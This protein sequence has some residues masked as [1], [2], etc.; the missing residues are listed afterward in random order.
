MELV[1][2][3]AFAQFILT[4]LSE[5]VLNAGLL[6]ENTQDRTIERCLESKPVMF[7]MCYRIM[8]V[9]SPRYEGCAV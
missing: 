8:H 3:W 4:T 9:F 5:A 7:N 2:S 1:F 6:K